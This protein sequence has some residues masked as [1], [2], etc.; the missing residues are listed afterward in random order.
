[1]KKLLSALILMTS[2]L[3]FA[4]ESKENKWVVKLNTTQ[5]S[6]E[7]SFPTVMFS[8]ER[9]VNPYFSIGAEAG[10]QL[11]DT[12]QPDST[13]L[14]SRGFKTNI[15]GRLYFSKLFHKRTTSQRNELFIALQ[16]FA[17]KNQYTAAQYYY[18]INDSL[19]V[20]RYKDFFGVKKRAFG[21]NLIFGN[22]ISILKSRKVILEPY[23]GIGY[24]SRKIKNTDLQYDETKH[25]IHYGNHEF[26]RNRSLEKGS[27]NFFNLVVG[28]RVGYKL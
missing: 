20:N 7:F 17:R 3:I 2:I 18:P 19:E 12:Y 8:A 5:L 13:M 14:N 21:I 25:E 16:F 10:I 1:M 4:Q 23:A 24:M 15:E 27:G 11:Y 26:F 22:Q 28:F 6:D 9:I